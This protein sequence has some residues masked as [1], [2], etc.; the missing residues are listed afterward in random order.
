MRPAAL[1][2]DKWTS[3]SRTF[4]SVA[5]LFAVTQRDVASLIC[6]VHHHSV[7]ILR[8]LPLSP[9]LLRSCCCH[10]LAATSPFNVDWFEE[11]ARSRPTV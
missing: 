2:F 8:L 10:H 9:C 6:L 3:A 1:R 5:A 4:F 7:I 11:M